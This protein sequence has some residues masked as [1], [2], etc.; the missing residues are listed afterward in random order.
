MLFVKA[1][2]GRSV[3]RR[4]L[5]LP[6][7]QTPPHVPSL[8]AKNFPQ[9]APPS[10]PALLQHVF[11]HADNGGMQLVVLR[12]CPDVGVSLLISPIPLPSPTL[13]HTSQVYCWQWDL[14]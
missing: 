5:A 7:P 13:S 9:A 12:C 10:V 2:W 1:F 11:S 6:I 3:L 8:G 14:F 4:T